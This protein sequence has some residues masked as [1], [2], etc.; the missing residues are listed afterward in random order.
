MT[1]F[2]QD[3]PIYMQLADRLCDEIIL[4]K[5]KADERIPSVREFATLLEVNTNT[6]VK[7]YDYLSA[8]GIIYTK[9]GLGFFVDPDAPE[10]IRNN[11]REKF[12]D[13]DVPEFFRQMAL[14]N[15][16]MDQVND[17]WKKKK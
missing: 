5:Y 4:E 6:I 15:I 2:K 8:A 12:F 11:R 10:K 9:R 3:K 1:E 7:T 14:L 16:T 17:L 13:E